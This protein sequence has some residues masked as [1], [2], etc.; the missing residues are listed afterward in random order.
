MLLQ[1]HDDV[2]LIQ[3]QDVNDEMIVMLL[4]QYHMTTAPYI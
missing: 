4:L 3:K 1:C 2:T